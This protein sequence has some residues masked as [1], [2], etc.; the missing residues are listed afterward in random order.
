MSNSQD[1]RERL[2]AFLLLLFAF[3][4]WYRTGLANVALGTLG[5]LF[6][7]DLP[8]N[9]Q[10][11]LRDPALWLIGGGALVVTLL[12][13]R[14][15]T[16]FPELAAEQWESLSGWLRPL[17]FILV[18]WWLRGD[19]HLARWMLAAA[20]V[21]LVMGILHRAE[22]EDLE[23]IVGLFRGNFGIS[24]RGDFGFT[25]LGLAFLSSVALLGL[26]SFDQE[27]KRISLM[28]LSLPGFGWGLWILAVVFFLIILLVTQ[29]RGATLGL[30][31]L[32]MLLIIHRMAGR[33]RAA[34]LWKGKKLGIYFLTG[35][36]VI[37]LASALFW[38]SIDR[39]ARDFTT[40]VHPE[41]QANYSYDSSTGTRLNLYRIG[42]ALINERPLLGW[43]PGTSATRDLVPS[44]VLDFSTS[45]L[46]GAP[47]W[48][49]LHSVPIE[50]L[51]RF[52]LIGG[53]LGLI[54]IALLVQSYRVM[55]RCV[56]DPPLYL[57]LVLGGLMSVFFSVYDFRLIRIDFGFF[58][59][60]FFGILYSF[61]FRPPPAG[62]EVIGQA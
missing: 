25:G 40:L 15:A 19:P 59:I 37:S 56:F 49:H 29:A 51:V 21:G 58:F 33:I 9:W 55:R 60:L 54:I 36:L 31:L 20:L 38:I 12:A 43:G 32:I 41:S 30:A 50:I 22:V 16:L 62:D 48:A 61:R 11:L 27:I 2:A 24:A 5:L 39:T 53:I 47:A 7:L 34:S 45:D 13:W 3:A 42:I 14:A 23:A 17:L 6:I 57:F 18:A 8:R 35:L 52:G 26:V 1:F 44:R 46:E 28:G 10:R 4:A